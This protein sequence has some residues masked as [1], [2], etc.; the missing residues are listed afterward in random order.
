MAE[1]TTWP[2]QVEK[3]DDLVIAINLR[4][5]EALLGVPKPPTLAQVSRLHTSGYG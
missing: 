1:P 5:K 2:I 4:R 3:T